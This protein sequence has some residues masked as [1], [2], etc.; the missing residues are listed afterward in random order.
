MRVVRSTKKGKTR[1]GFVEV[2]IILLPASIGI[3]AQRIID[4]QRDH[5]LSLG[6]HPAG[7]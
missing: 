2:S 4:R 1:I 5:I 7:N 3:L 6:L